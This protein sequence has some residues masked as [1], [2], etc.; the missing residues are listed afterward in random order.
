MRVYVRAC[1]CVCVCARARVCVRVYT[2]R[3]I[4][5]LQR[6]NAQVIPC[7]CEWFSIG[8]EVKE[9]NNLTVSILRNVRRTPSE[10]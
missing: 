7:S 4:I 8:R 9:I 6:T 10:A 5:R 2:T 3:H 1:M